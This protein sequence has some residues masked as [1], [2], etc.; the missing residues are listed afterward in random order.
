[1]GEMTG[2]L[3][4]QAPVDRINDVM[5]SGNNWKGAGLGDSGEVYL[6]GQGFK[7]SRGNFPEYFWCLNRS[8][9]NHTR[10]QPDQ[11]CSQRAFK[12]CS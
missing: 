12:A 1:M 5:T 6:V 3:I 4:F 11:G 10:F 9:R 7:R 8:G 2:V